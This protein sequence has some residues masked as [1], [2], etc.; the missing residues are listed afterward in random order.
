MQSQPKKEKKE[1]DTRFF[2]SNKDR[3]RPSGSFA[4]A[5]EGEEEIDGVK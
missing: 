5:G 1:P 3:N 4:S 2:G